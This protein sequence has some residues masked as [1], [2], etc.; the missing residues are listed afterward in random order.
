MYLQFASQA[1]GLSSLGNPAVSFLYNSHKFSINS[2][3]GF[4]ELSKGRFFMQ[5]TGYIA[6]S[7]LY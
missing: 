2:Y 5:L 6:T 7:P 1:R 3:E 4:K